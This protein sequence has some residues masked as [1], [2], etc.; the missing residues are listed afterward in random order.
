MNLQEVTILAMEG[1]LI[2][3]KE[4]Y[5]DILEDHILEDE[6][7]VEDFTDLE[8]SYNNEEDEEDEDYIDAYEVIRPLLDKL[9]EKDLEEMINQLNE[10]TLSEHLTEWGHK[11]GLNY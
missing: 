8:I 2:E 10:G 4:N 1:K 7:R 6:H 5:I 9:S 3:D 11:T